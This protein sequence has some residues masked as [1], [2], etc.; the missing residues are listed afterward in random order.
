V[1]PVQKD[2]EDIALAVGTANPFT[3]RPNGGCEVWLEAFKDETGW[4]AGTRYTSKGNWATYTPYV[5]ES[6]VKL[7]AG[8]TMEAGEVSFSSVVDGKVTITITLNCGWHFD[9]VSDNVKIQD[10]KSAPSGNPSPGKFAWKRCATK[11]GFSIKVPANNFYGVHV[12]LLHEY[13]MQ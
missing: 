12:D 9:D 13:L 6:T 11:S 7:F 1:V 3:G 8:Q 4:A 5:A 10:Y 2:G